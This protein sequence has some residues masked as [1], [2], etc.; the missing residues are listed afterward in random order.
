[1]T[2]GKRALTEEMLPFAGAV[3]SQI[4]QAL[5]VIRTLARLGDTCQAAGQPQAAR[6]ARQQALTI[7]DDLRHPDAIQ[8]RAT[9]RQP[10]TTTDFGD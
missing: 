1:M 7:L 5:G 4:G 10:R 2:S 3:G 9:L 8:V 6:D